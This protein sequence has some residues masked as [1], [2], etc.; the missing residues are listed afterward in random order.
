MTIAL[1]ILPFCFFVRSIAQTIC[2]QKYQ[3]G[4]V[5]REASAENF[6]TP[7]PRLLKIKYIR[8]LQRWRF[9]CFPIYV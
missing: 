2:K 1:T 8:F 9:N 7:P 3:S 6:D 5:D 4:N